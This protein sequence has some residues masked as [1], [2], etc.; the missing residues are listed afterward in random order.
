LAVL[1]WL[2]TAAAAITAGVFAVGAIGNGI[3]G[4][5]TSP[6]SDQAV[7]KAL[8]QTTRPAAASPSSRPSP[9]HTPSAT[10][11]PSTGRATTPEARGAAKARQ[12][13]G[14]S[15]VARCASGQ[16]I[17]ESWTPDQGYEADDVHRGPDTVVRV[18][19][20]SD[21][22]EVETEIGCRG[23]VPVIVGERTDDDH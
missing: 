22:A 14:G 12:V 1:G 23:G 4:S 9:T 5:T 16:A 3:A 18:K 2:A 11:G 21:R 13:R 17:L 7:A 6:L 10:S 8:A 15:V 19:F 20:K